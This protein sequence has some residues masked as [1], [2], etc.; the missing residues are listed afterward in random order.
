MLCL[1]SDF[2]IFP[3]AQLWNFPQERI[4]HSPTICKHMLIPVCCFPC[5]SSSGVGAVSQLRKFQRF[6]CHFVVRSCITHCLNP[7]PHK[8]I[9]FHRDSCWRLSKHVNV[10]TDEGMCRTLISLLTSKPEIIGYLS[11]AAASWSNG[12]AWSPVLTIRL[13]WIGLVAVCATET[14]KTGQPAVLSD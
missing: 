12:A 9:N 1:P 11:K 2:P 5:A 14:F 8:P 10:K 3:S 7:K 6:G 13:F 4:C